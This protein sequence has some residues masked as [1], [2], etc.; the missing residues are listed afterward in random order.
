MIGTPGH[1]RNIL[2]SV[3]RIH[4][5]TQGPRKTRM[6]LSDTFTLSFNGIRH[7]IRCKVNEYPPGKLLCLNSTDFGATVL[8][9]TLAFL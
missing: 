9:K 6:A 7:R 4:N 5:E 1:A 8:K 2:A 3:S